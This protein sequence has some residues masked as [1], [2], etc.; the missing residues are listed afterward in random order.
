MKQKKNCYKLQIE[1]CLLLCAVVCNVSVIPAGLYPL[2]WEIQ[3]ITMQWP[4]EA[5]TSDTLAVFLL[6]KKIIKGIVQSTECHVNTWDTAPNPLAMDPPRVFSSNSMFQQPIYIIR[7]LRSV[8]SIPETHSSWAHKQLT[9][10]ASCC[11]SCPGP[12]FSKGVGAACPQS[13]TGTITLFR[14]C[15]NPSAP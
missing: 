10:A 9:P 12:P 11:C 14:Y 15:C 4:N 6:K 1:N 8:L 7:C 2:Q 5:A 3:C 13:C